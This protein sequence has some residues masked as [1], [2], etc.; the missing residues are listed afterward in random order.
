MRISDWSS[1][2]CSSD[3]I[4]SVATGLVKASEL[5]GSRS[6]IGGYTQE[7]PVSV[8]LVTFF[9][10][11]SFATGLRRWVKFALLALIFTGIALANYR[12]SIIALLPFAA[13]FATNR[14]AALFRP[15]QR[16]VLVAAGFVLAFVV[17]A[18]ITATTGERFDD[19][20]VF[21]TDP[22]AYIKPQPEFTLEER[23]LLSGRPYKIGRAHV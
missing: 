6:Y 4:L 15:R 12:T 8:A 10:V 16:F 19:L 2:V 5:D 3:L 18:I 22:G 9:I 17:L 14:T 20:A 11:A 23:R 7:A 13:Y 1:D 21:L